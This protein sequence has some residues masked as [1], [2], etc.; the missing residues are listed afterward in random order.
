MALVDAVLRAHKE[1]LSALYTVY[2]AS[3][4]DDRNDSPRYL[5]LFEFVSFVSHMGLLD[6][7]Q[8]SEEEVKLIFLWSRIRS[9]HGAEPSH[10]KQRLRHLFFEDFLEALVRL[11]MAIAL[12]T[13]AELK[14]LP[15]TDGGQFLMMLRVDKQDYANWLEAH[16]VE[17][18]KAVHDLQGEPRQHVSRC[19]YHLL[20]LVY[21][22]I[23]VNTSQLESI[24]SNYGGL[25]EVNVQAF[26]HKQAEGGRVTHTLPSSSAHR[27]WMVN[28][29]KEAQKV[30]KQKL[31]ETPIFSRLTN[32]EINLLQRAM[33][34][35]AFSKGQDVI[36]Q[37]DV[38]DTFYVIISGEA[39]VL[40]I[41]EDDLKNNLLQ[42]FEKQLGIMKPFQI[43]GERAL[44]KEE[45]RK[46]TVRAMTDLE[47]LSI[48]KTRFEKVFAKPFDEYIPDKY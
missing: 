6:D 7:G 44:L 18:T 22:M 12:P 26:L 24:A 30:M 29:I 45:M 11:S 4:K 33:E 16:R 14:L 48:T 15:D 5:S 35:K 42:F 17:Q 43:F 9:V 41:D 3:N 20:R 19:V 1:S 23:H 10:A 25:G 13:D 32:R 21:N 46:A 34:S 37:G 31:R 40:Q 8:L 38:G 28:T 39:E 36:V 47:T 2:A 27:G